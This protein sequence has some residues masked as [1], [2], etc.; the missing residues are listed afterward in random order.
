MRFQSIAAFATLFVAHV[1]ASSVAFTIG[2]DDIVAISSIA[3]VLLAPCVG[4]VAMVAAKH[5]QWWGAAFLLIVVVALLFVIIAVPDIVTY[6]CW[7]FEVPTP[8]LIFWNLNQTGTAT[9]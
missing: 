9:V 4:L 2:P 6:V 3:A 7:F 5:Y 1:A 8:D